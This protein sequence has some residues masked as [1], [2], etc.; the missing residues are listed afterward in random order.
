MEIEN[1][2]VC[3]I[4]QTN[5]KYIYYCFNREIYLILKMSVI[6]LWVIWGKFKRDE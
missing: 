6:L 3:R 5:P 1:N 4:K 2:L